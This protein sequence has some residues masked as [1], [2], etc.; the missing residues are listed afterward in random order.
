MSDIEKENGVNCLDAWLKEELQKVA[1][2]E[3]L[4]HQIN[5]DLDQQIK[6]RHR[7]GWS[8]SA[9]AAAMLIIGMPLAYWLTMGWFNANYCPSILTAAVT[10]VDHENDLYRKP[11][12]AL[13]NWFARTGLQGTIEN[14]PVQFAK[15]CELE[16]WRSQHVRFI[17]PQN[18]KVNLFFLPVPKRELHLRSNQGEVSEKYWRTEPLG[19]QLTLLI[20][21]DREFSDDAI[22][23]LVETLASSPTR[24]K[25]NSGLNI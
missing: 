23:R 1:V 18:G 9:M 6:I 22:K 17:D 14:I 25:N 4:V 3:D 7:V 20:I 2:P 12:P 10:Q 16:A 19:S 15:V 13:K 24:R 21:S 8:W 11:D 5:V